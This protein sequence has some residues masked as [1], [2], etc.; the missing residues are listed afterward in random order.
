MHLEGQ[1]VRMTTP[2]AQSFSNPTCDVSDVTLLADVGI[3]NNKNTATIDNH[4][5]SHILAMY[6]KNN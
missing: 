3:T 1:A 6:S 4:W 5:R 2:Y